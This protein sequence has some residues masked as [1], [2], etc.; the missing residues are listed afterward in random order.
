MISVMEY[1]CQFCKKQPASGGIIID[2]R[3]RRGPWAWMCDQCH[4]QYGVGLG[5]GKG[6]KFELLPSGHLKKIEG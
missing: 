4:E 1:A 3:T 6:Q 5:T 2:G